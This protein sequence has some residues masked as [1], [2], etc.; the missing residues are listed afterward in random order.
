M[1][2]DERK[3][4]LAA[5]IAVVLGLIVGGATFASGGCSLARPACAVVD[6]ANAACAY[7]AIRV[8]DDGGTVTIPREALRGMAL[9]YAHDAGA[10][11]EQ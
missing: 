2:T 9:G 5:V 8:D 4:A 7:V 3:A 6:V 1:H 11:G 10:G